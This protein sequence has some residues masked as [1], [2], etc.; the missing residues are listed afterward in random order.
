[1]ILTV[2]LL[3]VYFFLPIL[4]FVLQWLSLILDD[5]ILVLIGMVLVI[6]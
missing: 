5:Q 1:M 2:L 3:W 4:A 6:V